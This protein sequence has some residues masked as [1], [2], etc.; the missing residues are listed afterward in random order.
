MFYGKEKRVIVLRDIHSNLFEEAILVMKQ[1]TQ[2]GDNEKKQQSE[3]SSVSNNKFILREA[4]TIINN[5]IK[6][7]KGNLA[8]LQKEGKQ[9]P[10]KKQLKRKLNESRFIK[11]LIINSALI[12]SIAAVAYILIEIF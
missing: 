5:Y 4:E 2:N 6:E 11:I 1:D 3:G 10:S 8:T 7:N 9:S 12:G